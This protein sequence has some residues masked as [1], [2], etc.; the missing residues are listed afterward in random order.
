M[1][2]I[3][4]RCVV[5]SAAFHNPGW[6]AGGGGGRG[7]LSTAFGFHCM[8]CI[9]EAGINQPSFHVRRTQSVSPGLLVS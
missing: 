9:V 7:S 2:H 5:L 1:K 3:F 4:T 8:D 6:W